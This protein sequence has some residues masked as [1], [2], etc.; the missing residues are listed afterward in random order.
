MA[1]LTLHFLPSTRFQFLF[2]TSLWHLTLLKVQYFQYTVFL[3][4]LLLSILCVSFYGAHPS[5]F[6]KECV[7][8]LGASRSSIICQ[9]WSHPLNVPRVHSL[10]FSPIISLIVFMLSLLWWLPNLLPSLTNSI[11]CKTHIHLTS[12]LKKVRDHQLNSYLLQSSFSSWSF[13]SQVP[14]VETPG[15]SLIDL[16]PNTSSPQTFPK[17]HCHTSQDPLPS[18]AS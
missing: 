7:S 6:C 10:A 16:C 8:R 12:E 18:S 5:V 14:K 15:S 13:L 17:P 11:A 3:G 1:E 4:F 9:C 2:F